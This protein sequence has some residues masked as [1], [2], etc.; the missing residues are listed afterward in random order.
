MPLALCIRRTV[1]RGSKDVGMAMVFSASVR[2]CRTQQIACELEDGVRRLGGGG[3]MV[4]TRDDSVGDG[5]GG[6]GCV[7][8]GLV[9]LTRRGSLGPPFLTPHMWATLEYVWSALYSCW[10][11]Y[12]FGKGVSTGHIG[13]S[14]ERGDE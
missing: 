2:G 13:G 5:G 3:V 7:T 11:G 12:G 1:A 14:W 4:F 10:G 6:E 9:A 8:S